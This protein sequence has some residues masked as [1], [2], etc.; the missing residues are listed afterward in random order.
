MKKLLL[1]FLILFPLTAYSAGVTMIGGSGTT[2]AGKTITHVNND[3]SNS[4]QTENHSSL[5]TANAKS[6]TTGNTL[7]VI[8]YH[9]NGG[10]QVPVRTVSSI[11]DTETNTYTLLKRHAN[12]YNDTIE[13]WFSTNITG[14]ASNIVTATFSDTVDYS[15]IHVLEFSG[16]GTATKDVDC[17]ASG[18]NSPSACE[19]TTTSAIALLVSG[20]AHPGPS[21]SP[22]SGYTET[23]TERYGSD[24]E[25]QVA[26]TTGAK[27]G[28]FSG[29][30]NGDWMSVQVALK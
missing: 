27:S 12:S 21:A 10:Y 2:P 26:S 30:N 6:V 15:D 1:I 18:T 20:V 8:V 5:S 16:L 19:V 28:D 4:S 13:I 11:T 23:T 29:F 3:D 9:R 17:G 22:G 24:V 14:N 7:V 25:W